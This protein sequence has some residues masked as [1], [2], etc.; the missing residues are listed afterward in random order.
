MPVWLAV[1]D[2]VYLLKIDCGILTCMSSA[3]FTPSI[4]GRRYPLQM[5]PL[6]LF[7]I[8]WKA[9]WLRTEALPH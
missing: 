6:P 1:I 2:H 4:H 9:A 5:L 8:A 3:L 7:E